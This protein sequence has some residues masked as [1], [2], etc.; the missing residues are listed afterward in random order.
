MSIAPYR[1]PYVD[2][3]PDYLF[4]KYASTVKR[5]PREPLVVLPHTL[6]EVTAPVFRHDDIKAADADL[7]QQHKGE[8]LG[9]RI[10]VSGRVLDENGRP[11]PNVL[12]EIWQANAAG[13]YNHRV[14]QH[15][16][17]IDPNFTGAGRLLTDKDGQ[18]RFKTIRPGEYPWRNHHNA[19]R[20]AHIHFSLFGQGLVQRL[21]TQMYFPGDPLLEY[22]PMFMC[23]ADVK[24]RHRLISAFD[25]ET[26]IPE[27]ALGYRWDIVLRGRD[28][29]PMENR[30]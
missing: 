4:P 5:S 1:R 19:W 18:Y 17:P 10:V 28:E 11:A 24:A 2:T 15:D 23:V 3:Q 20:P 21:I 26:T 25:W 16:A 22:D 6:S 12:I 7:T 27:Y 29:T 30:R 8:P 9:E 14:D 13:R